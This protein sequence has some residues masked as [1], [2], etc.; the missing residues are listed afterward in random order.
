MLMAVA[1]L[2]VAAVFPFARPRPYARRPDQ[3]AILRRYADAPTTFNPHFGR[4]DPAAHPVR[5]LGGSPHADAGSLEKA[6]RLGLEKDR[7][8]SLRL[9]RGRMPATMQFQY[10][11]KAN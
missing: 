10:S 1:A 8:L 11:F 5:F 6:Q 7:E 3:S 9:S 2:S 4:S